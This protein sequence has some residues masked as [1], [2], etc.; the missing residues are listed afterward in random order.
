MGF[1]VP[2]PSLLLFGFPLHCLPLLAILTSSS[3]PVSKMSPPSPKFLPPD[4]TLSAPSLFW[5]PSRTSQQ[6][7]YL[8][9]GDTQ[10]PQLILPEVWTGRGVTLCVD[11]GTHILLLLEQSIFTQCP[12]VTNSDFFHSQSAPIWTTNDM[13]PQWPPPPCSFHASPGW[14]E[15]ATKE[16]PRGMRRG[17]GYSWGS[18]ASELGLRW[19]GL[20]HTGLQGRYKQRHGRGTHIE[21]T[22]PRF[23]QSRLPTGGEGWTGD[24]WIGSE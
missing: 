10:R 7:S 3:F 19:A 6:P 20:G 23:L 11:V 1:G 5:I 17:R 15:D 4:V 18:M 14:H 8:P 16:G 12:N 9:L 13:T 22:A 21:R 24:K 2:Y